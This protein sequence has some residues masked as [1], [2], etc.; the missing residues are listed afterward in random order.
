MTKHPQSK[1]PYKSICIENEIRP[2]YCTDCEDK[3]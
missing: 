2:P 3:E 1:C